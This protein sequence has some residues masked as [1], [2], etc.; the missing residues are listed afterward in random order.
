[1]ER[2]RWVDH[3]GKKILYLDYTGLRAPNPEDKK[4][5]LDIIAKATEI[6]RR[7]PEKIRFLSDVTN[8]VSDK[9]VVNALQEFGRTTVSL[10]K[11]EKECAVGVSGVQKALVAMINLISK[12][13]LV[14]F[15]T[16]DKAMD[17]LV[18]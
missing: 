2:V 12:T 4:I 18:E 3:K 9:E 17:W 14:M 13:K 7:S 8:T 10:G 11:V 15:D 1:M 5:V 6:A 16:P